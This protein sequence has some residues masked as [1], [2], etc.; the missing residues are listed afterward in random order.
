MSNQSARPTG[1]TLVLASALF[2]VGACSTG[3]Q[4]AES[5]KGAK[6]SAASPIAAVVTDG[7]SGSGVPR[8]SRVLRAGGVPSDN[9]GPPPFEI[10]VRDWEGPIGEEAQV[11]VT[12]K[13]KS[14]FKIN[15]KYPHQVKLDTPPDGLAVPTLTFAK[16][17]A[18]RNGDA[19][20]TYTIVATAAK[21]GQYPITGEIKLSVC[22]ADQCRT[23]R[24]PMMALLTAQ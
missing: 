5:V 17:H 24:E 2:G 22:S 12:V 20:I 6:R 11:T 10:E 9:S 8:G 14:G 16:E 23:A 7:P 3:S 15:D 19:S 4:G 13:A 18:Q 21:A 1:F